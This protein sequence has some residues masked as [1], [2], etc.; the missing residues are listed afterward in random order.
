M[1]NKRFLYCLFFIVFGHTLWAQQTITSASVTTRFCYTT[2]SDTKDSIG[3]D[4]PYW[5]NGNAYTN[6]GDYEVTL[7]N[8]D[9]CDSIARLHLSV[10][11]WVNNDVINDVLCKGTS[12]V[13]S[14][15]SKQKK[16]TTITTAGTYTRT[17]INH[18]GCDSIVQLNLVEDLCVPNGAIK[19]EF[20]ADG[21]TFYI[22]KGNLQYNA[23]LNKWRMADSQYSFLAAWNTG[24]WIDLFSWGSGNNPTGIINLTAF[25]EWGATQPIELSDGSV[26]EGA[27]RTLTSNEIG[28][29]F[30]RKK[31]TTQYWTGAQVN[32]VNGRLLFPDNW[33]SSGNDQKYHL[34]TNT[35]KYTDNIISEST[36][37]AMEADGV[38]FFPAAGYRNPSGVYSRCDS[39]YSSYSGKYTYHNYGGY[40][41]R[42]SKTEA[43]AY[44]LY[45]DEG[46]TIVSYT[47]K[48]FGYSVRLV[49]VKIK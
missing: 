24:D 6:S 49:Q 22:A 33:F 44:Y 13:W 26:A 17:F 7:I 46:T 14:D 18:H 12:Y 4:L 34:K 47:S 43:E 10:F 31:G 3:C 19:G 42:S 32:G 45:L 1:I 27:W 20:S 9:G 36:W 39:T 8:A 23:S 16:D 21:K 11:D 37:Q 15:A 35:Y 41:T 38:A 5:W 40:W 30:N 2:Y 25:S 28:S 48:Q 29:L